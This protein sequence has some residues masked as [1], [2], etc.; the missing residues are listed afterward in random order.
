[1][2]EKAPP[3]VP[4]APAVAPAEEAELLE[5]VEID[6]VEEEARDGAAEKTAR[7][8]AEA[9]AGS[10]EEGKNCTD[11]LRWRERRDQSWMGLGGS[12]RYRKFVVVVVV[13][14][15]RIAVVLVVVVCVAVVLA[16]GVF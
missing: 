16:V 3:A 14:V 15:V 2:E 11:Q 13:V 6:L 8:A 7:R 4:P 1:M 9:V 10:R 5:R 12:R